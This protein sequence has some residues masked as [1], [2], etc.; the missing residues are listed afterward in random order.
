LPVIGYSAVV[1]HG[2]KLIELSLNTQLKVS[3]NRML[4]R[5]F[6]PKREK[7]KGG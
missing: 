2:N 4:R 3:E 6:E 1:K 5:I 7:V